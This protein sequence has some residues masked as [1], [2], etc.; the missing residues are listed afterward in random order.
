MPDFSYVAR[1]PNGAQATGVLAAAS[2]R[3]A[4]A[5][6]D[7]KGLFPVSIAPAK[8]AVTTA[9]LGFGKRIRAR[10]L[11]TLYAQMADLLH[12]GVPLLRS[13]D[14]LERQCSIPALS[15]VLRD[16]R[17][18]VADGTSLAD[19][20]AQHPKA[21]NELTVSMVRAGQEGG[22]LE[23]VLKRVA[24]FTDHQEELKSKVIGALAYP[25]FLSIVGTII[26]FALIIFLVPR[27]ETMFARFREEGTL[28][29]LTVVLLDSS[30]ALQTHFWWMIPGLFGLW[31]LW[32]RWS[33]TPAGRRR[34]DRVKLRLPG[35]GRIWQ[36]L[37]IARFCRILGTMLQNGIPILNALRIAK[38]S[39][40]NVCLTEAID[41]A[42]DSVKEGQSLG[43]PLAASGYFPTDVVEM[44]AIGEESN[45]LEKVLISIADSTER[46]TARQLELFVRLLEPLMLLIMAAITLLVVLALLLPF[47]NMGKN[48]G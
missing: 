10:T 1:Q 44:V 9:N 14:I 16:V 29:M 4:M 24:E 27:F 25:L 45:T 48:F 18:R 6:L 13:L 33:Q 32:R 20:M 47:L 22:F 40:G 26:V 19:A 37:A 34:L 5:L 39:T 41:Q 28:P 46:R 15:E 12:S 7:Q 35:A 43:K 23:D 3:E 17:N 36:S 8:A 21:F 38:D 11:A 2:E 30:R 42:A 31:W